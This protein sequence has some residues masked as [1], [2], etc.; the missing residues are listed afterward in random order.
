MSIFGNVRVAAE[1]PRPVASRS[2]GGIPTAR[3]RTVR[4]R[5][6]AAAILM[7]GSARRLC[8]LAVEGFPELALGLTL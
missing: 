7:I 2:C 3:H 1:Q 6:L 8:H 4:P 5:L